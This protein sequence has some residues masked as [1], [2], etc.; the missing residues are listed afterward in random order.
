MERGVKMLT[1][2]IALALTMGALVIAVNPDYRDTLK[3]MWWGDV[4]AS[5]I[6]ES[7]RSYYSEVTYEMDE[8]YEMA[9]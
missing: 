5:A 7:N 6:W 8:L 4:E 2:I 9:E 1:R 3:A